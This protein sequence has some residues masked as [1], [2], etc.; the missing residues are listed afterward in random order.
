MEQVGPKISRYGLDKLGI[1]N[2]KTAYWNLSVPAYYEH[3]IRRGEGIL[4]EGG[5]FMAVTGEHT[6]RSPK[7]KFIVEEPSSKA[8]IWW[9]DV[10]QP[11]SQAN[12]DHLARVVPLIN[13]GGDVEPLIALQAHELAVELFG[14]DLGDFRLAAADLAFEE[15][16]PAEL[17]REENGGCHGAVGDIVAAGQ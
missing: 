8:D 15:Q 1:K 14:Q 16:R 4:T 17:Q 9:G 12:F 2:F 5:P 10:N 7:D 3:A 13:G 11:I 6:G